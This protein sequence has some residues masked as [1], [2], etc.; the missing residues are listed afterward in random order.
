MEAQPSHQRPSM[1]P[2]CDRCRRRKQK[3]EQELK[4][5]SGCVDAKVECMIFDPERQR[6]IPRTYVIQL[7]EH[8]QL[9]QKKLQDDRPPSTPST[10]GI[11]SISI[12]PSVSVSAASRYLG[13]SSGL[14][15]VESAVRLAQSRGIL[16]SSHEDEDIDDDN[17]LSSGVLTS[18]LDGLFAP[19]PAPSIPGRD[20]MEELF[21]DF[22]QV[23]WQYQILDIN[24][25]EHHLDHFF[26]PDPHHN[27]AST[28]VVNMVFAISVHFAGRIRG[29]VTASNMADSY[30]EQALTLL[31][32]LL[33]HKTID[34]LQAILLILLFSIVNPQKPIVWHLL[35]SA[36]RLAS[37]LGIHTESICQQPSLETFQDTSDLPRRLFWSLY[38]MDRAVGNTLG[39][40]TALQDK[41]ITANLP[42]SGINYQHDSG[43]SVEISRHCFR[44]RQLQSEVADYLYQRISDAPT[45]YLANVQDRL[46]VWRSDIPISICTPHTLDWFEH[47]YHNLTMFIHRPSPA[48]PQ[49]STV[50][51]EKCFDA[52]SHVLRIYSRLQL[53]GSV[54][55]TWMAVHWLFLAAVTHLFCLWTGEHLRKSANWSQVN[56]DIRAASMVLSAMTERWKSGRKMLSIYRKLSKGTLNRYTIISPMETTTS[57]SGNTIVQ[58]L[59]SHIQQPQ[60]TNLNEMALDSDMQFWL[61]VE[62]MDY[63]AF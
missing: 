58:H 19:A 24:E 34:S 31:G 57:P 15:F 17:F 16:D 30:H 59:Q 2:V 28:V 50:H 14:A 46:D 12:A 53:R 9:L 36:L 1:V 47:S 56:E 63:T 62:S 37:E 18:A 38:S 45:D 20:K 3:C 10:T 40:P 21:A 52:A 29:D 48:N 13:A 41:F 27:P 6:S 61:D 39:R 55:S 35:G 5:C 43:L 8:L 51:L 42:L 60:L 4:P 25:F 7:E 33:R 54:D 22:A 26:G 32:E 49:P 23:Q 44:I 11:P